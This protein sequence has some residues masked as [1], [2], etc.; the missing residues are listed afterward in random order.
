MKRHIF[1]TAGLFVVLLGIFA[2]AEPSLAGPFTYKR[3]EFDF[4]ISP[5]YV[6][7]DLGGNMDGKSFYQGDGFIIAIPKIDPG[8]GWG[9]ELGC[10]FNFNRKAGFGMDFSY[11]SADLAA[12]WDSISMPAHSHV[13]N[14]D[15]R[16]Y[17]LPEYRLHTY[18]Q[19]GM[20][21]G[22]LTVDNAYRSA[23]LIKSAEYTGLGFNLGLGA[24]CHLTGHLS[25][26]GSMIYRYRSYG[27]VAYE[28]GGGEPAKLSP[29]LH[30]P[31]IDYQLG[32]S[33]RTGKTAD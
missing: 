6:R 29:A 23:G 2:P 16:E 24:V 9:A 25:V 12:H 8:Y 20:N 7:Q 33:L 1:S 30:A 22:F 11:L 17:L 14:M 4:Y 27:S 3:K 18:V 10:Q 13:F 5:L 21:A 15:F 26:N 28:T 19:L 32:I 31:G